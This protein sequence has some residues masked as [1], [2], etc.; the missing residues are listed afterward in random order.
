MDIK[1][2]F[3]EVNNTKTDINFFKY[4]QT[5]QKFKV[6]NINIYD[7]ENKDLLRDI[8]KLRLENNFAFRKKIISN[9]ETMFNWYKNKFF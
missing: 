5:I 2:L 8:A 7:L 4:S 6:R 1:K 9:E 3:K